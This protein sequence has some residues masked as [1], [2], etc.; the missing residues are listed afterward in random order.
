MDL[1]E[2][3]AKRHHPKENMIIALG[4]NKKQLTIYL[5]NF[6]FPKKIPNFPLKMTKFSKKKIIGLKQSFGGGGIFSYFYIKKCCAPS[7]KE[8]KNY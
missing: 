1:T 2:N 5:N 3:I 7:T 8:E 6:I 4:S